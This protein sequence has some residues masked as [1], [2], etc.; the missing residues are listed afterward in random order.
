[1]FPDLDVADASVPMP[2]SGRLLLLRAD[3]VL[4]DA[5]AGPL[6]T[7]RDLAVVAS[8]ASGIA[9]IVMDAARAREGLVLLDAATDDCVRAGSSS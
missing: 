8:N 3:H 7:A 4:D 9:A 1:M 5:L 6:A 2:A